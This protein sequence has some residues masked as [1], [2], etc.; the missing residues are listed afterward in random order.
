VKVQPTSEQLERA[1]GVLCKVIGQIPCYHI[2]EDFVASRFEKE[3]TEVS[4]MAMTH[5]ASLDSA[6][7]NLR[8]FNE[9]FKPNGR[10]DD[11]R[12]YHFSSLA[13]RPFLETADEQ[14]INKFLAHL[15]LTWVDLAAMP[16]LLDR[17]TLL[18]L[19]HGDAFLSYVETTFPLSAESA[20]A[21]VREVRKGCQ[22][23]SATIEKRNRAPKNPSQ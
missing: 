11:V 22:L 2:F 7:L 3:P 16:W 13:M 9:F 20:T 6:L 17:M 4:L 12:A 21:E 15:T 10:E 1:V 18:G 19:Q 14:A 23:F 8:C 5:N